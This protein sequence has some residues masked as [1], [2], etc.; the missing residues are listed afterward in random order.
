MAHFYGLTVFIGLLA[1]VS[2]EQMAHC[3]GL[4]VCIGVL[5]TVSEKQMVQC[6]GLSV[7]TG[8]LTTVSGQQIGQRSCLTVLSSKRM[9]ENIIQTYFK[10]VESGDMDWI[11][12][13]FGFYKLRIVL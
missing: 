8:V 9:C 6:S 3:S 2:G 13:N 7:C 1:T 12:R 5:A 10:V 4:S 11:E